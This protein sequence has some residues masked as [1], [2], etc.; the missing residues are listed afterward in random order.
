M[1][2]EAYSGL[3]YQMVT[4]KFC[5]QCCRCSSAI[6]DSQLQQKTS[7][8]L[9]LFSLFW[10][11]R[12]NLSHQV[13]ENLKRM[14]QH[15]VHV[16]IVEGYALWDPIFYRHEITSDTLILALADVSMKALHW[17]VDVRNQNA[18]T[19]TLY[20]VSNDQH[21][22]LVH[23]HVHVWCKT[24]SANST[25]RSLRHVHRVHPILFCLLKWVK[26]APVMF[27]RLRCLYAWCLHFVL[28]MKG[29]CNTC[30]CTTEVQ[31]TC[32]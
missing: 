27:Y 13:I 4:C 5:N 30:T 16:H 8:L 11:F 32:T 31:I 6:Q 23:V 21:M 26:Q 9:L 25:L 28:C 3:F 1:K 29:V 17:G 18:V 7:A 10:S 24:P 22:T 2:I 20:K 14:R 15:L 12:V 19:Y